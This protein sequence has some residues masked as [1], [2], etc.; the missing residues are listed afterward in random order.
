MTYIVTGFLS[1]ALQLIVFSRKDTHNTWYTLEPKY[2]TKKIL[3]CRVLNLDG[4]I[5]S[6]IAY[7]CVT[8]TQKDSAL[9]LTKIFVKVKEE[10]IKTGLQPLLKNTPC[11][12]ERWESPLE[13]L[14]RG[15]FKSFA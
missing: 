12:H 6:R 8:V 7:Q 13:I 2:E 14:L 10:G 15:S 11:L 1:S 9:N 3:P 5:L 4:Q